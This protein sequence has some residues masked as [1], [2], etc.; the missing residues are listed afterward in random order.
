MRLTQ[1]PPI[2]DPNFGVINPPDAI[3]TNFPSV[4]QG[5]IGVLLNLVF[6]IMIVVA[7]IYALFNFILA[8]YAFL[9]AGED[10]KQIQAAWAKIYQSVI[11]LLFA[12][13]SLVLAAI[14]GAIIFGDAS[15]LINPAIP[16]P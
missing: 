1:A 13:G 4:E 2:N 8:G 11:G 12:A 14:F 10:P 6:N 16:L 5:A 15:A 7:G 9:S 3:T